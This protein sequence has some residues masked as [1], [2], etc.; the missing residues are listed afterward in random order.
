LGEFVLS[1]KHSS[2]PNGSHWPIRLRRLLFPD[3]SLSLPYG[4]KSSRDTLI[5]SEK[6]I[7]NEEERN[8]AREKESKG[9]RKRE[10]RDYMLS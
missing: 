1:N 9:E 4:H 7:G 2:T 6:N 8:R 10:E 5:M 3:R